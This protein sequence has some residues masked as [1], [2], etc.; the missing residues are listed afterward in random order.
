M[1]AAQSK[2]SSGI[3]IESNSI[4]FNN[5]DDIAVK[6]P[7]VS[8]DLLSSQDVNPALTNKLRLLNDV[9]PKQTLFPKMHLT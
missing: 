4:G 6:K 5:S 8:R 7:V 1:A 2:S 3:D 9:R